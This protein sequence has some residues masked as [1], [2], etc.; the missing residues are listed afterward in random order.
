M[1]TAP[2]PF[3]PSKAA[4]DA[5]IT[6]CKQT[7]ESVKTLP[8]KQRFQY[9]D[10]EFY[11]TNLLQN[12][13]TQAQML[14]RLGDKRKIADI[15][16]PIVEP[17]IETSLSF[18]S[19]VFLTGFPIFGI[20]GSPEIMQQAKALEAVIAENSVRGSW[21]AEFL[22]FFRDGLKYNF[23]AM[24]VTWDKKTIYTPAIVTQAPRSGGAPIVN[25]QGAKDVLWEGN[26]IK[27]M[28]PYNTFFDV[29]VPPH[30]IHSEGEFVGYI[31][32]KSRI[33]LKQFL[34]DLP[35]RINVT[36]ALKTGMP[37]ANALYYIPQV[38]PWENYTKERLQ[39]VMN[40]DMWAFGTDKKLDYKNLYEVV[41]RYVRIMP[42]D[43]GLPVP[44]Q[45]TPQIWKIITVNDQVIV[46]IERQSNA[47]NFLPIVC[48][49]PYNDGLGLQAK[50][51]G[52]KL[53]PIQDVGSAMWNARLASQRRKVSDRGL[54]DPSR[55]RSED[56]N[57]DNPTAKIPVKSSAYGKDLKEAYHQIPFEDNQSGSFVED[58][59]AM[60][61]FANSVTGQNPAQQGNFVKGNK[62]KTEYEDVQ[63]H[64]SGRQRTGAIFI[65]AQTMTP[66]KEMLKLNMLQYQ[67]DGAIVNPA[68]GKTYAFKGEE[69]R[70]LALAFKVSDGL[71][72]NDKLVDN[73][74]L[75]TAIQMLGS[76][77]QLAQEWDI[78]GMLQYLLNIRGNVDFSPFRKNPQQI[79]AQNAQAIA[80]E[81]AK[82]GLPAGGPAEEAA[83]GETAQPT[84]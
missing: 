36:D 21:V 40:W 19:S 53:I 42:S 13:A 15:V 75:Q 35:T 18:L 41:T 69:L 67:P 45:N 8:M 6:Y 10:T 12:D 31:E 4:H 81:K 24:E 51:Q 43:F 83:E 74:T 32:I 56:I 77:P 84:Q 54:Y 62:T 7:V 49:Q 55:V 38:N 76:N 68:D 30:K 61:S 22:M 47:H 72:P 79:A 37:G 73:D 25:K 66:I 63:N 5:L 11:R 78:G 23:H 65:E 60:A 64:S 46:Y 2:L 14:S 50:G 27:R 28:D 9:I 16:M 71:L 44:N 34:Q 1:A 26:C 59:S 48:G 17:Q 20:V 57:S 3:T 80:M 82:R 70:R 58:G 29:R 33:A 52:E 39:G